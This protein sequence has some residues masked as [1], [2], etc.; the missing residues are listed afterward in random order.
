MTTRK[1]NK[2]QQSRYGLVG[3]KAISAPGGLFAF[4]N[5]KKILPIINISTSGVKLLDKDKQELG[6]KIS[7][8]ISVPALGAKPLKVCGYV[9]WS[10]LFKPFDNYQVGVKFTSMNSEATERIKN[11]VKFLG[12]QANMERQIK[13]SLGKPRSK[14]VCPVCQYAHKKGVNAPMSIGL[15]SERH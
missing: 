8:N 1:S 4:L 12:N 3:A 10:K 15:W 5:N 7:F 9:V 2:R 11:L 6:E 14:F 13:K